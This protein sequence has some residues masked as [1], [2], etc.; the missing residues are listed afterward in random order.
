MISKSNQELAKYLFHV[1]NYQVSLRQQITQITDSKAYRL[2]SVLEHVTSVALAPATFVKKIVKRVDMLTFN[3]KNITVLEFGCIPWNF[4]FQRPQHLANEL[5]RNGCRVFYFDPV[6]NVDGNPVQ[7]V[8]RNLYVSTPQAGGK[9]SIHF[10]IPS[11]KD[12]AIFDGWFKKFK[13]KNGIRK[14][15]IKI[16]HPFWFYFLGKDINKIVYDCMDNHSA[17]ENKH[18]KIE[19]L[20][21][22]LVKRADYVLVSSDNLEKKLVKYKP[23][24]IEI[25]R[26]AAEYEI[27]AR[28]SQI[29]GKNYKELGKLK[30]PILG[31]YGAVCEWFDFT[32]VSKVVS[33][34]PDCSVVIIGKVDNTEAEKLERAYK[35]I[36]FLGEKPY[37]EIPMYLSGFD[38]CLIP[39]VINNLIK[40]TNPVKIYEYFSAGK[41]V[42]TTAVPELEMYSELLYYSHGEDQF[43]GNIKL[44]LKEG[45]RSDLKK[46]RIEVAKGNTWSDRGCQMVDVLQSAK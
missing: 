1:E 7:R 11:D 28:D 38:V 29:S 2:W 18:E 32:L 44:A 33:S 31:Y 42:V 4:R 21:R 22:K 8:G 45:G 34:F 12:I 41:A 16:D 25:L 30:K 14:Y 23:K 26:N 20:E 43:I 27:F 17:F 13:R 35:N 3:N 37:R 36:H 6:F 10:H 15:L 39:F 5:V 24:R 40:S 46:K 9:L 19:W